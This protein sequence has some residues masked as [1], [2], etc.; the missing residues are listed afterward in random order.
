MNSSKSLTE[1]GIA[2]MRQFKESQAKRPPVYKKFEAGFKALLD[3][4]DYK[5]YQQMVQSITQ[6]FAT[7]SS[8]I[9]DVE[10]K[11]RELNFTSLAD[12]IR[13]IQLLERDKLISTNEL[14]ALRK[15][16]EDHREEDVD[17]EIPA[18]QEKIREETEKLTETIEAVNEKLEEIKYEEAEVLQM[19]QE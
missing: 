1:Q 8:E 7:I 14:Q 11:L 19:Y 9:R 12:L 4:E 17:F 18:W 10:A 5:Q 3:D 13:E 6:E 16:V 2:L 15:N